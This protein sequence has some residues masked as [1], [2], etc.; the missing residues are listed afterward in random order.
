MTERVC[1]GRGD[2]LRP[3]SRVCRWTMT[4]MAAAMAM[5]GPVG[6]QVPQQV[7]PSSDPSLILRQGNQPPREPPAPPSATDPSKPT[8]T[9]PPKPDGAT[10]AVPAVRFVLQRV[11]V[12]TSRLLPADTLASAWAAQLGQEVTLQD[13]RAIVARINQLYWD[14]G[15]YAAVASLP[16]QKIANGVLKINLVEG[17]VERVTVESDDPDVVSLADDVL[18]LSAGEL[19]V[20]PAVQAR[21]ARFNRGSDTRFFAALVPGKQPGTTEVVAQVELAP[22]YDLAVSL[23]NEATDTLGRNQLDVSGYVRRLLSPAD[24]LGAIVQ[25]TEGSTNALVLYSVPVHPSGLRFGASVSSGSTETTDSGLGQLKVEGRSRVLGVS[26]TQPLMGPRE[27]EVDVSLN[28]QHITSSTT[29][30]GFDQGDARTRLYS[31]GVQTVYRGTGHLVS[32]YTAINGGSYQGPFGASRS[33]RTVNSTGSWAMVLSEQWWLNTRAGV[34]W[35]SGVDI[36]ATVKF[37]LGNPTDVRGYPASVVFGDKGMYLSLEAHRRFSDTLDVFAFTDN[38][39]AI[40]KGVPRQ[41]LSSVGLGLSKS[42]AR[43]WTLSGSV[44]HA[45]KEAVPGQSSVR[46]LVRLTWQFQ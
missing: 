10:A 4:V 41:T 17:T 7:S 1:A 38:G 26:L 44:A 40:T 42:W 14:A 31:L 20:G 2:N 28:A 21:L 9:P 45:V 30:A 36:P 23:H 12:P 19:F 15:H 5:V 3:D 27:L 6:A 43:Q 33:V 32:A 25:K 11:E 39:V 46:G 37:S 22:K 18:G 34:Q 8:L 13:I 35:S 29:I 16:A 24:R